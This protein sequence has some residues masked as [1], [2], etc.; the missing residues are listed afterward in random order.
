[1]TRSENGKVALIIGGG[2]GIGR[3]AIERLHRDGFRIAVGDMNLA[4]ATEVAE[5]LGGEAAG[6]IA[7][8]VN[9]T[10][11]GS[12]FAAVQTTVESL[13]GFDVI[14]NN[15]GIAP[16]IPV[17]DCTEKDFDTI[18]AVNV[19]GVL[20]GIQAATAKLKELGHGGKIISAT[21]QAGVKGNPGIPLYSATK[22]AVRGLTQVCAQD[23]AQY[24]ITVNAYAP[25][26]V[27]TPLM[28]DL[29]QELAKNAGQ[30]EEWG[31]EQF[32]KNI[33]MDRL[34]ESEDVANAISFLASTDSDY[35]TGQ[36]L[37][38]DGGMVFH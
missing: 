20:W 31:W 24:G 37:V 10:D 14:I 12:V 9:A 6:A 22:F 13:G 18:F 19:K 16:Q 23:L 11:R 3:A 7:I 35:M 29:A 27:R 1:M 8:E 33:S 25:G 28:A 34:S 36:T 26:I 21:S 38:V 4:T 32:T 15:A 2:Q 17:E 30:P 5:G